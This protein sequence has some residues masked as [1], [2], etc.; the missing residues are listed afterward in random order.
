MEIT[1]E[2]A[3]N[4]PDCIPMLFNQACGRVVW[5]LH[6]EMGSGKTTI[7]RSIC[8]YLGVQDSV[9]SPS[10]SIVNQYAMPTGAPLYHFDFYR[11]SN[12]NEAIEAG[13]QEYLYSGNYCFVEWPSIIQDILPQLQ[14]YSTT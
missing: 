10:F 9:A 5:L 12:V 11:L 13:C 14:V 2:A 8:H 1:V 3:A 7:I 6:G 4:L